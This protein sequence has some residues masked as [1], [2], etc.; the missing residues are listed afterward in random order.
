MNAIDPAIDAVLDPQK[1]VWKNGATGLDAANAAPLAPEATRSGFKKWL[2]V[3]VLVA[4]F[5]FGWLVYSKYQA[6]KSAVAV[7]Q[8][9]PVVLPPLAAKPA[10]AN[11]KPKAA[12]SATTN[13]AIE[14]INTPAMP[15]FEDK[16]EVEIT[17]GSAPIPT[18]PKQ[19]LS[20]RELAYEQRQLNFDNRSSTLG[21]KP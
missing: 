19:P 15:S 5:G 18:K 13:I 12:Q 8:A 17:P 16:K 9:K 6:H 1:Q 21:V 2:F 11:P 7:I 3:A 4:V 10:K 20:A 14:A